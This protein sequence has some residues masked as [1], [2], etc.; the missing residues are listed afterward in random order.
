MPA[1][2]PIKH[3]SLAGAGP[4]QVVSNLNTSTQ[5]VGGTP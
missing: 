5:H 2:R 3:P 4:A 1:V